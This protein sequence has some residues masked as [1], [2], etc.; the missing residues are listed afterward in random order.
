MS[1]KKGRHDNYFQMV[2][3]GGSRAVHFKAAVEILTSLYLSLC[4]YTGSIKSRYFLSCAGPT[5]ACKIVLV[6]V[7]DCPPK[8]SAVSAAEL[9]VLERVGDW[10]PCTIDCWAPLSSHLR[11][12]AI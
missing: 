7:F 11:S 2:A 9:I 1:E 6:L 5:S 4:L 12:V 3:C 8:V 10:M